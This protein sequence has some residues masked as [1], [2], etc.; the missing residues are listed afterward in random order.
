M[1]P[2]SYCYQWAER[3]A[4]RDIL[5][6]YRR[7]IQNLAIIDERIDAEEDDAGNVHHE[8]GVGE[9]DALTVD[10]RETIAAKIDA[11]EIVRNATPEDR[12]IMLSVLEGRTYQEIADRL[13]ITRSAVSQRLKRYGMG[14]AE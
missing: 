13:G 5:R 1:S 6:D 3:F 14:V 4:L 2:V 10:D 8:I 12:E 11:E 9:V 7:T